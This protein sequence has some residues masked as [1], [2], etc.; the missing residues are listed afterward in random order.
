MNQPKLVFPD[1]CHE[2]A[3]KKYVNDLRQDHLPSLNGIGLYEKYDNHYQEWIQKEKKMH[4]GVDLEKGLVPG[5]TLLYMMDKEIIGSINI[6]HCL[7]EF[8]YH[9]GGHIGYSIAPQYRQK[10]YATQMLKEV[11]KIC[12]YWEIWPVLITCHENNIA[13]KKTIEKC[14]GKF[15]NKYKNTLR[16]WIG[17]EK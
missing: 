13:S 1:Y 11:L 17:E 7:N 2:S 4:L 6:R 15:E 12:Q 14:G 3:M 8:L 10:G 9:Q 5:T 16:Y